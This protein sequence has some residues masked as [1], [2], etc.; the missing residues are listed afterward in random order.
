[1]QPETPHTI[2]YNIERIAHCA[3]SARHR[4]RSLAVLQHTLSPATLLQLHALPHSHLACGGAPT[5]RTRGLAR[6]QQHGEGSGRR[7]LW[8]GGGALTYCT[9]AVEGAASVHVRRARHKSSREED[10]D[11]GRGAQQQ[12]RAAQRR[13]AQHRGTHL[14][15]EHLAAIRDDL[16]PHHA[17]AP[18]AIAHTRAGLCH[19][20]PP[21][22]HACGGAPSHANAG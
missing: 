3:C 14:S 17:L 4:S 13:A 6:V 11:G 5:I 22:H 16:T 1:M 12:Q 2:I 20:L 10:G 7:G 15:I 9:A 21:R 19:A 18:R 8:G